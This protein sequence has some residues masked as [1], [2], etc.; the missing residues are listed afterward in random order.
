[1]TRGHERIA[2]VNFASQDY[3]S[4]ASHP[5]VREAAVDAVERWG[6]HSA[7]S[8]ALQGGSTPLLALEERL[9]DLLTCRE[10]AVFASGWA[11]GYGVV[12]ALVR[13]SDHIVI[14][15]AAQA[16][17]QDGAAKSTRNIHRVPSCSADLV[18]QRLAGIR[19]RDAHNGILVITESLF[20]MDS[21]VPDLRALQ[22]AC[23]DHQATLLVDVAHDLGAIGDGGLGFV[24]EQGMAGEIDIVMGSFAP[25]FASNGGFVASNAI[26]LKQ[27]LQVFAAP[28]LF[29]SA[30]SPVQAAV[31][32]AALDVVRSREG[33]ERRSR[34]MHNIMRLREA[35][36]ARA[37]CI[38]GRPSAIIPVWLGGIAQTRLLTR[39]TLAGGA[40]VNMVEH[41]AVARQN[42]RWRLQ[43]MADHSAWQIDQFVSIAVAAR[44]KV[45]RSA[46]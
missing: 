21:T 18:A 1:M 23:R 12:G 6:V 7:G 42:S 11:A 40:L 34:L 10:V 44:E 39:A 9:A 28:Q 35:L 26:G 19:E 5:V 41:P 29:S 36:T 15:A 30:L 46:I 45:G 2:G 20:S 13:E 43:V 3:L 37:F 38:L 4:L 31:V 17:L 25:T 14:D 16:S 32:N 27:A 24:G 33:A 8:L 22:N